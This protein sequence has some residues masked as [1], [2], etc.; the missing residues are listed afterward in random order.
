MNKPR[1]KRPVVP[2]FSERYAAADARRL[3]PTPAEAE[4]ARILGELGGGALAGEFRREWPVGDWVLDFYFPSIQMAIEVDGGYHRAQSRWRLDLHKTRDLKAR[5]ITV[6]RLVNAEVFGDRERLVA[7]LRAAWR[8]AVRNIRHRS[9]GV[10][11]PCVPYRVRRRRAQTAVAA[12]C[13]ILS[14]RQASPREFG[15]PLALSYGPS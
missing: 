15:E 8:A 2:S 14:I 12:S 3:E 4:L 6:L 11:E 10:C 9:R 13:D 5:G 1:R 7:R